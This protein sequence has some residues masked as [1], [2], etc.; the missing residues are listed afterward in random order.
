MLVMLLVTVWTVMVTMMIKESSMKD[1][2]DGYGYGY[3]DDSD[4]V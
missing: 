2:D 1:S 3:G 4:G